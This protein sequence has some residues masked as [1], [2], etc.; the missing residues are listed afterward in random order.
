MSEPSRDESLH[1][2]SSTS[3][4][5]E[6]KSSELVKTTTTT[7]ISTH[8][9][10]N[11]DVAEENVV[12]N[13]LKTTTETKTSV[14][15]EDGISQPIEKAAGGEFSNVAQLDTPT[16]PKNEQNTKQVQSIAQIDAV[17]AATGKP[18]DDHVSSLPRDRDVILGEGSAGH[19]TNILLQ[20]VMRLHRTIWKLQGKVSPTTP[21]EAYGIAEELFRLM[22]RG[23]EHE[24]A[25][26][27]DVP[28][29]FMKSTGRF[30]EKDGDSWK[31]LSDSR[32]KQALAEA[33]VQEFML[34]DLGDLEASPY[35]ELKETLQRV[36]EDS[37][38]D[39][40][41]PQAKDA[42]LLASSEDVAGD[43]MY[44]QQGGN[45]T[46][47]HLASQLV[48]SYTNTAEKRVESALFILKGLD[49]IELYTE[50][51]KEKIPPPNPSRKSRFLLRSVQP[52][53]SIAWKVI[54]GAAAA[55]FVV[56]FVFEVFLEKELHLISSASL[57]DVGVGMAS[58]ATADVTKAST[59]AIDD[60]TD[61]DVLFGRG[62][63]TNR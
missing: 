47:F 19:K 62:G 54:D 56:I 52:D 41:V 1:P 33:M 21:D 17:V 34:D 39:V 6:T 43:K 27:K 26:I 30:M 16:V 44:E 45:R 55:E 12:N 11:I 2:G 49:E 10:C 13:P 4:Q 57:G 58:V 18:R 20:D 38:S 29:P 23:K 35:K 60:P 42:I 37:E 46:I 51:G 7:A 59:V 36:R 14:T 25:G 48:S 22:K 61:Y 31:E 15:K 24:L 53:G 5:Y 32:A 28:Y 3:G 9:D 8:S 50:D 40:V 63:M